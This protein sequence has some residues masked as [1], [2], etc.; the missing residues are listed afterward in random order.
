MPPYPNPADN[1]YFGA[2]MRMSHGFATAIKNYGDCDAYAEKV[3]KWDKVKILTQYIEVGEPMKCGFQVLN[4]GD[5]WL[6][7]MMFKMDY[8]NNAIDV[9]LIDFQLSYWG[10]PAADLF[11]LM[12]TSV[13]DDVKIDHFDDFIEHYHNELSSSLK[14]L[15]YSQHIPTLA[16]LHD[17]LLEKGSF[18]KFSFDCVLTF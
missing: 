14:K 7:N 6:N 1:P 11:M 10:S 18:S 9:S 5:F 12:C 13:A 3:A 17:D 16:E 4:H 2:F 8:E 15:N